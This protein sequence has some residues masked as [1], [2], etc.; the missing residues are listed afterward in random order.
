M[1]PLFLL[2][3]VSCGPKVDHSGPSG[4]WTDT[5]D[6]APYDPALAESCHPGVSDWSGSW[7]GAEFAVLDRINDRRTESADCG[8][9]G[10]FGP[11]GPL[12]MEPHLQCAARYHS[13]WMSE[14]GVLAHESPGGDMGEGPWERVQNSGFSG[15]A[16]GENVAGGYASPDDVVAGWMSSDGHCANIMYPDA[17]LVGVGYHAGG[18]YWTMNTGL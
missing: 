4:L 18:H 3:L 11:A 13:L 14:N 10:S 9:Q 7:N 15:D 1:R 16:L 5:G 8:T 17:V 12:D 2:L 6:S